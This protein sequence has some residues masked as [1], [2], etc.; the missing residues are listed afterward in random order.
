[1]DSEIP[2]D[3]QQS[4]IFSI[5]TESISVN[6]LSV[7]VKHNTCSP[8]ARESQSWEGALITFAP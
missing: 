3:Q 6:F 2:S 4:F 1:M 5:Y 7:Y 8:C